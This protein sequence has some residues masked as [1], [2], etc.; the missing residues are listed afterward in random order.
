M[1]ARKCT[2]PFMD[3][4]APSRSVGHPSGKRVAPSRK[5]LPRTRK[6]ARTSRKAS[7]RKTNRYCRAARLPTEQGRVGARIEGDCRRGSE[8]FGAFRLCGAGASGSLG[9]FARSTTQKRDCRSC[10][11]RCGLLGHAP[12]NTF[13]RSVLVLP[14]LL[15]CSSPDASRDTATTAEDEAALTATNAGAIELAA[16]DLTFTVSTTQYGARLSKVE[17]TVVRAGALVTWRDPNCV[18][19]GGRDGEALA[20][21]AFSLTAAWPS[22]FRCPARIDG[23]SVPRHR[24]SSAPGPHRDPSSGPR[25][26]LDRRSHR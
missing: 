22:V 12:M 19:L 8:P 15:G 9:R 26:I 13:R 23:R 20:C 25:R 21:A 16:G 1:R 18:L 3:A 17:V 7:P 4:L 24:R 2:P 10:V 6:Y 11:T 5:A 14:I